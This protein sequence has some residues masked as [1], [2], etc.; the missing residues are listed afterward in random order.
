MC[1]EVTGLQLRDILPCLPES[2]EGSGPTEG[3]AH[4][5]WSLRSC[6]THHYTVSFLR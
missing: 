3:L 6:P 4:E 5:V 2:S 1:R